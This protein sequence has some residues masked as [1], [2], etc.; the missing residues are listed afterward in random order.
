MLEEWLKAITFFEKNSK[1]K[2]NVEYETI[3]GYLY[4]QASLSMLHYKSIL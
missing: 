1:I 4:F 2:L 3:L